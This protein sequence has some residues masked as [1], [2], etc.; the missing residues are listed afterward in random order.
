MIENEKNK[1]IQNG[2]TKTAKL[3]SIQYSVYGCCG[4][5]A[6]NP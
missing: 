4:R 1:K 2:N 6:L 3:A 5:M